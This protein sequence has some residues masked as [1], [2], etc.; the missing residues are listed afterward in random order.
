MPLFRREEAER[1]RQIGFEHGARG[2]QHRGP[3]YWGGTNIV[4]GKVIK[5]K[6]REY[7]VFWDLLANGGERVLE[8]G[9]PKIV[10]VAMPNYKWHE[11][12]ER[13]V[14]VENLGYS[15]LN[16]MDWGYIV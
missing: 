12:E 15:E 2:F 11:F 13:D 10:R 5:P 16:D 4:G 1:I 14:P 8:N 3:H 9:Q 6:G 7:P